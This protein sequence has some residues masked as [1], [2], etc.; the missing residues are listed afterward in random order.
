MA[1]TKKKI[2][3]KY[4]LRI[5][6]T[7]VKKYKYI[8]TGLLLIILLT[9]ATFLLDR[10]LFKLLVDNG[11][12][13]SIGSIT[14]EN[15]VGFLIFLLIVFLGLILSRTLL[16]WLEL[17]TINVLESSAI[18][19]LKRKY[20]NHLINLSHKFFTSVKTGAL[21][22][23]LIRGGKAIEHLTDVIAFNFSP[24]IFQT[25]VSAAA[26][27]YFDWLSALITMSVMVVFIIFNLW[28]SRLQQDSSIR[29]NNTDDTE[30]ANISDIFTNIDSIKYFGKEFLIKKKFA[31]ISELTRKAVLKNWNYYRWTSAGEALILG[32]GTFL[33]VYFPILKLLNHEITIGT[34]VFIYSTYGSLISPLFGFVH[35]VRTFYDAMADFESLFQYGKIKNE[36]KD[37]ENAKELK[38]RDG[39]IEF[40]NV[41]FTYGNRIIF[42]NFN[43]KIPKHKKVALVGPSGSG[44]TTLVKLLYRFYDVDS[45]SILIDGRDI[46]DFK[47]ESL[48]SELSIVPQECILFDDTIYNNLIFSNPKASRQ[49]VF[50]A[51]KFAQLDKIINKFPKK[52]NTIVG[53]RGVKL[54][55]GEKQRVSIAR[56]L[57][58][59]KKVL[60]LDEAT[61]SLDSKTEH[62]IQKDLPKL[63]RGRTSVIIAH[64]L[65]TI[66][67][68][69][70]IIVVDKEK[71]VQKGKHSDLIK[72]KG[73][74]R[75]LW[76]LQRGGYIK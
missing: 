12:S 16:N 61:S 14:L 48:R 73:M 72:N 30:K 67:N 51:I 25:L 7:L 15:F 55:G 36:I 58:A 76:N 64:R 43:L 39:N 13:F 8:Y 18:M 28:M 24:L 75:R 44:K 33:I 50:K 34:L 70:M 20:F 4:N 49:N 53:E 46:R 29:R 32:V 26:L 66:M 45:G 3:Y 59:N 27:I 63:M 22:S 71:V 21:I 19:D 35:G 60:V 2:D 57:L 42:K 9:Q 68:A 37:K 31:K 54:S 38:I 47:Q 10:Y 52:E 17:H 23:K 6:Y 5:Y 65:S 62:D 56:A 1:Y 40:K 74:Y 69:D 11:T 41:T